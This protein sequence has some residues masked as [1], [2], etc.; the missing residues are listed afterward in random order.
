MQSDVMG[1]MS[2]SVF[3][4]YIHIRL[5]RFTFLFSI[6]A[7]AAVNMRPLL[8]KFEESTQLF[9]VLG[10]SKNVPA[11]ENMWT[12]RHTYIYIYIYT[13]IY[14][15]TYMYIHICMVR[16][17]QIRHCSPQY[18]AKLTRPRTIVSRDPHKFRPA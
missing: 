13:Y 14:M 6:K 2:D 9:V 7:S 8:L 3:R 10:S 17:F 15:Y 18:N 5:F 16:E 12:Y 11:A 4:K 1:L